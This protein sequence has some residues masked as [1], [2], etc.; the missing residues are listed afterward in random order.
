MVRHVG[1]GHRECA[2]LALFVFACGGAEGAVTGGEAG[3]SE[4]TRSSDDTRS[5]ENSGSEDPSTDAG[6]MSSETDTSEGEAGPS[7]EDPAGST[8]RAETTD[9]GET[10]TTPTGQTAQTEGPESSADT[11]SEAAEETSSESTGSTEDPSCAWAVHDPDSP[12]AVLELEGNLGTHDPTV[13]AVDGTFYLHQTGLR[14]YGKVSDD[15]LQ[16]EGLPSALQTWPA[17]IFD[18]V[19]GKA[20]LQTGR[21]DLWAPD[22]SFFGGEFHLYYSASTF[23]SQASCIGQATRTSM[24]EGSWTDR[25]PVFCS[26]TGDRYNA[27]DPNII[28]DDEGAPWMAFGS[29]WDGVAM[30]PLD[31]DGFAESDP[32][33][34]WLASRGGGAIEAP[35]IVKRCGMYYLFVSFDACCDQRD[36]APYNIRVGRSLDLHGPY[37]DREGVDMMEGGGTLVLEGNTQ[38]WGVGHNTVLFH[39]GDAYNIYHAYP[40]DSRGAVLRVAQLVWDAEGWPISGGP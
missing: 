6:A 4:D 22:L 30:I 35:V 1:S 8:S 5:T 13:L 17:W 40:A 12:P 15:L 29:F 36:L 7:S 9:G 27:I 20:E 10:S 28:L 25:G 14:I 26:S 34:D 24:V 31:E 33:V 32:P 16:W 3:S 18:A 2:F 37:L 11:T 19:P 38:W 21:E 23:G 39:E